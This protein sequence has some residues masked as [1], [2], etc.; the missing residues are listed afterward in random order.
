[1]KSPSLPVFDGSHL[2]FWFISPYLEFSCLVLSYIPVNLLQPS[3]FVPFSLVSNFPSV[4]VFL[5]CFLSLSLCD[6]ENVQNLNMLFNSELVMILPTIS[7]KYINFPYYI[8]Q[9]QSCLCKK[10]VRLEMQCYIYQYTLFDQI[11]HQHLVQVYILPATYI[12][13]NIRI[14]TNDNQKLTTT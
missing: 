13:P 2:S 8:K 12:K 11:S 9:R 3:F 14:N 6:N 4:L 10:N 1:M 5:Y 7:P